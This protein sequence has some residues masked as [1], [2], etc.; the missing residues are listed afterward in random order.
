LQIIPAFLDRKLNLQC[1]PTEVAFIQ[2]IRSL[3]CWAAAA[4]AAAA[5]AVSQW[6]N[7][8]SYKQS[9]LF[10]VIHLKNN[11]EIKIWPSSNQITCMIVKY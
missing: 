5:A 2:K 8:N 9:K 7:L 3:T 10:G 6:T 1:K 4:A 11:Y